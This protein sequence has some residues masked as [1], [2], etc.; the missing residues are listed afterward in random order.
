MTLP[1]NTPVPTAIGLRINGSQINN[2]NGENEGFWNSADTFSNGLGELSFDVSAD[3]W[4][5]E[6]NITQVQINY[7]RTD[8]KAV[9]N[10][11][12]SESGQ[13]VT[14]N[15]TRNGGIDHF[16][17]NF[18]NYTI[19]F[20]IP[21]TWSNVRVFNDSSDERTS[22]IPNPLVNNG[23]KE[24]KIPNAGN[25]TYWFLN[26]TSSNLIN[27]IDTYVGGLDIDYIAN[28][29]NVVRFNVT[30]SEMIMNGTLNLSIYSPTPNFLNHT[31]ILNLYSSSKTE[32]NITDWDLSLNVTE[33]G[34]FDT[35]LAW[36]NGTAVILKISSE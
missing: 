1:D 34:V 6:C 24:I 22:S 5:V 12:I 33:Y 17:T 25:G 16:D 23:Y 36:N 18:N 14:W 30:F 21:I 35:R 20:T 10:F 13:D 31:K 26:A 3:W 27:S 32:F 4:D 19:N 28:Y 2:L 8:L 9:S 7:T 15:V 11:E 29:T